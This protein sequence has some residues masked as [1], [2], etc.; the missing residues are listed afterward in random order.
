MQQ[1]SLIVY[2]AFQN[3]NEEKGKILDE[4]VIKQ[5]PKVI[6]EL[7]AYCGYSAIRMGRLLVILA[8]NVSK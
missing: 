4:V 5:R 3:V 2:A 7:G 1:T 6:I 8:L